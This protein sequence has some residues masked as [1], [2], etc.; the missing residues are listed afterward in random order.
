MRS[1]VLLRGIN[2]GR[3]KRIAMA[4]LRD[5]LAALG[6]PDARTLLQSGN[7]VVS[8]PPV[9]PATVELAIRARFGFDVRVFVR[10][11]DELAGVVAANPLP[12]P[13]GARFLV[14]FLDRD[15]DPALL[16]PL[17][18][19]AYLPERF[20][21]GPR[22]AYL[23]CAR[24]IIDSALSGPLLRD[25]GVESTSRNWNTVTKLLELTGSG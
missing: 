8:G 17:D 20:A 23:W 9:D 2:V 6:Y 13:D 12:V 3:A 10:T 21:F 5:L 14:S 24:G 19:E 1:V 25:L 11:R 22:V 7:A 18:P 15:P 4:D 16:A